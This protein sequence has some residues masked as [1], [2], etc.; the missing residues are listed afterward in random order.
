[1][2]TLIEEPKT[3][4][5]EVETL[6]NPTKGTVSDDTPEEGTEDAATLQK[7]MA[8]KDKYIKELEAARKKA[9]KAKGEP[10][11]RGELE[12]TN[13]ERDNRDRIALVKEEYEKLQVDGFHGE[14]VSKKI[15]LELAEKEA[16]IDMT[17]T[18]RG[19]QN[20]MSTPSVTNR[21]PNP[22]GY[23]TEADAVLGLTVEKKQKMEDRHPH[24]KQ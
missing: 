21:N 2:D 13:W 15:A 14:K 18:R 7:R 20:D 17:D 1:M 8:D 23:E 16:K 11:T 24:L 19:R 4:G 9:E 10:V 22:Q 5:T 3:S 6:T 12:E